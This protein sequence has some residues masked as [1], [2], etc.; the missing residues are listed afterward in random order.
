MIDLKNSTLKYVWHDSIRQIKQ[1]EWNLIFPNE[2]LKST[3][4]FEAME[5]SFENII[6][7]H[8][9]CVY[10]GAIIVAIIPCFEYVLNMD[11]VAPPHIQNIVGKIRHYIKGFF[12]VKVLVLGSY[13]ASCEQYIGIKDG[14]QS[15]QLS[16]IKDIITKKANDTG[17]K[18]T[19][20]KE[21]PDSQLQYIKNLFDNYLFVDSLPNSFIPLKGFSPYPSSL[22]TKARQRYNRA[23]RDFEKNNLKLE[24]HSDFKQFS[25]IACRLYSNV[26]YKSKTQ[27]E[28]LNESF[29]T[30][31]SDYLKNS[32]FLL[33]IRDSNDIIRSIELI[34]KCNNKLIPI[35]IGID[36]SFHDV[37]CLYFNTIAS[38]IEFAEKNGCDYVVLGQNNYFPK[39]LSGAIIQRGYLG[40]HST[41]WFYSL[42]INKC[43]NALF[44][45]FKNEFG[46][47]YKE[48]SIG[49]LHKFSN[50]YNINMLSDQRKQD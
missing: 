13:I 4:L 43:F 42:I 20:I 27:F 25:E 32:S 5:D 9:L 1:A 19:M 41:N 45:P 2:I 10:D 17:C 34:F 44:P 26:L 37:K 3:A 49:E 31:A 23:K 46:I 7:Y 47:F 30:N 33:V 39:V 40:F 21:V 12:S 15:N 11:V 38:S 8:Y 14:Y 35:Y 16:S 28:K 6:K 48:S 18:I 22:T 50:E 24:I 29:F 36:Y